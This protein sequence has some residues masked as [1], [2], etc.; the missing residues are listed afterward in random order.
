MDTTSTSTE[1]EISF[2]WKYNEKCLLFIADSQQQLARSY[3]FVQAQLKQQQQQQQHHQQQQQQQQKLNKQLSARR[4][5]RDDDSMHERYL[6][7]Q[8]MVDQTQQQQ[9][10][11]SSASSSS[12]DSNASEG[13]ESSGSHS[14]DPGDDIDDPPVSIDDGKKKRA[15]GNPSPPPSPFYGNLLVDADHLLPLQHYI[16]QQAKLSGN[17]N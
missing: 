3:S 15:N 11:L 4:R 17:L 10:A 7:G 9:Q 5:D 12:G 13:S 16:L 2:Y 8:S 6:M 14:G 1:Y